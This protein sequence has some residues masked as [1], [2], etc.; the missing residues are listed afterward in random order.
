MKDKMITHYRASTSGD[1]TNSLPG[2]VS[3]IN[4]NCVLLTENQCLWPDCTT[5]NVCELNT[6]REMSMI[7]RESI[8]ND[9]EMSDIQIIGNN[10]NLYKFA[11]VKEVKVDGKNRKRQVKYPE[12]DK[13]PQKKS[14]G[15]PESSR[16]K[17]YPRYLVDQAP[18]PL[19]RPRDCDVKAKNKNDV[20]DDIRTFLKGGETKCPNRRTELEYRYTRLIQR[21]QGEL[22]NL[23]G[24]LRDL[25]ARSSRKSDNI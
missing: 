23:L 16:R 25:R 8:K 17:D 10:K 13:T 14:Q 5:N 1:I 15:D 6:E 20:M 4:E 18:F 22:V 12:E 9:K 21:R 19:M 11:E 3:R 7:G 24:K 2:M